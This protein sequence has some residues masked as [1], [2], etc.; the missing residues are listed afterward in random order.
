MI[1]RQL[2]YTGGTHHTDP[3]GSDAERGAVLTGLRRCR[4]DEANTWE[5]PEVTVAHLTLAACSH[6]HDQG[7]TCYN[8]LDGRPP[9]SSY[10]D[11][12]HTFVVWKK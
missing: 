1:C 3:G 4:G 12:F 9:N 6:D 2:G 10:K 7:V 11:Y 8:S 5:C